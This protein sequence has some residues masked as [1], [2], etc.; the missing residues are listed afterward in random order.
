MSTGIE[1]SAITATRRE[2]VGT[3]ETWCTGPGC[4]SA[5]CRLPANGSAERRPTADIS[6]R[7]ASVE[8]D[9]LRVS[10]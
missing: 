6:T 7:R 8:S 10:P 2:S 3:L 4:A 1:R 5:A 9:A